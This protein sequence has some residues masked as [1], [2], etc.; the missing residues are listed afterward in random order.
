M[1]KAALWDAKAED[2]NQ[3]LLTPGM[4]AND[5]CAHVGFPRRADRHAA[6][7]H[8]HQWLKLSAPIRFLCLTET[9]RAALMTDSAAA[10][11]TKPPP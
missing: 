5:Y 8:H 2:R 10:N 4:E 1:I 3:G 11:E 7:R 6:T 9:G